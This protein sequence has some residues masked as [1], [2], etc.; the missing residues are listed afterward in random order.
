M[1]VDIA[2]LLSCDTDTQ[3]RPS[4]LGT[5]A[6]PVPKPSVIGPYQE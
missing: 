6:D 2:L 5:N 1:W 4:L 3:R